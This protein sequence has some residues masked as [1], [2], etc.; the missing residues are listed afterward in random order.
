MGWRPGGGG[1]SLKR[2]EVW[3]AELGPYLSREQTGR[4]PVVIWQS[5]ELTR[6]LRSVLV[7]PPDDPHGRRA[8][9]SR[10]SR[11]MSVLTFSDSL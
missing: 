9:Q 3:W 2:G 6:V 8:M 5:D 11:F 4:R 7:V 10:R 1:S